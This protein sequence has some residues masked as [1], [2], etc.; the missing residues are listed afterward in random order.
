[1]TRRSPL[2]RPDRVAR[3]A[4]RPGPKVPATWRFTDF[5]MI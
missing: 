5:A 2:P 4:P 1:M 3:P